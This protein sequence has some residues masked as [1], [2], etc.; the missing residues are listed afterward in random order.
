MLFTA[1][2]LREK[3]SLMKYGLDLNNK[4]CPLNIKATMFPSELLQPAIHKVKRM[5]T[6]GNVVEGAIPKQTIE[7]IPRRP[8]RTTLRWSLMM[9]FKHSPNCTGE[10]HFQLA[11]K[12]KTITE[13]D[14][15]QALH[16]I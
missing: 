7:M 14:S 2:S 3:I 9:D 11:A 15:S 8:V 16:S 1:T 10:H 13:S 4:Q 6:V 5:R 12:T